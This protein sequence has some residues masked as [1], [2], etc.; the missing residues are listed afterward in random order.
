MTSAEAK[1]WSGSPMATADGHGPADRVP[2]VA[3]GGADV[4]VK[5]PADDTARGVR[6]GAAGDLL[7]L[8]GERAPYQGRL[9]VVAEGALADLL[10]W[11]GDLETD[12]S[13][14]AD[15]DTHLRFIMKGGRIFKEQLA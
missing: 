12:L 4:P 2:A 6:A 3:G 15:P 9:G 5:R 8:S 7:A 10:A 11:D 14:I 13:P 1:P